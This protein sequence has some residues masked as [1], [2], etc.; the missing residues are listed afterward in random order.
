[1]RA[2]IESAIRDG[3]D[4]FIMCVVGRSFLVPS[5]VETVLLG[6]LSETSLEIKTY[7]NKQWKNAEREVSVIASG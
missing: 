7:R 4:S 5:D 2:Q 1:M 3:L 6:V